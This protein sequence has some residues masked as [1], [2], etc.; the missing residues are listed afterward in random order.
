[1]KHGHDYDYDNR[2]QKIITWIM[3]S[4][5]IEKVLTRRI[6]QAYLFHSQTTVI[7]KITFDAH[8]RE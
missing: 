1:M 2:N 4:Y 7:C 5:I 8:V 6:H 3:L